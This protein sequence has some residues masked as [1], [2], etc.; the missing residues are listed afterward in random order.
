MKKSL[1]ILAITALIVGGCGQAAKEQKLAIEM[2]TEFFT[3]SV[4]EMSKEEPDMQV[5]DSIIEQYVAAEEQLRSTIIYKMHRI[6]MET[7]TITPDDRRKDA[8]QV[9]WRSYNDKECRTF[10]LV[11][12]KKGK[13][14]IN[15]W[16]GYELYEDWY[17]DD[18]QDGY[19]PENHVKLDAALL[20]LTKRQGMSAQ[21]DSLRHA[22]AFASEIMDLNMSLLTL[23]YELGEDFYSIDANLA[24]YVQWG[25]GM[26]PF[27]W[28]LDYAHRN[29]SS[30]MAG[31]AKLI[32]RYGTLIKLLVPYEKYTDNGWDWIVVQ[33][34][35]AY[36][37][38]SVSADNFGKVYEIM[39]D[40]DYHSTE[41]LAPF[42]RDKQ[43]TVFTDQ[44][45]TGY[46]SR[47][48]WAYSFWGRRYN[49]NSDNIPHLV[50]AL[51]T[52]REHYVPNAEPLETD[53]NLPPI[54]PYLT[55]DLR[56]NEPLYPWKLYTDRV[57][58]V[59][60]DDGHDY[61]SML[62]EKDGK[63]HWLID[64][65][66]GEIIL[67]QGDVINLTWSME[68]M[69]YYDIEGEEAKFRMSAHSIKLIEATATTQFK[70]KYGSIPE[71]HWGD[72]AVIDEETE[73]KLLDKLL[74][75]LLESDNK[76]I[77]KVSELLRSPQK[78]NLSIIIYD[79]EENKIKPQGTLYG[80]PVTIKL[81][82]KT[83]E[84][85]ITI[86]YFV[87]N[88][89]TDVLHIDVDMELGKN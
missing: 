23:G 30:D 10:L 52:I 24:K 12:N 81:D 58:V 63:Q 50:A 45:D 64:N 16:D 37:D 70:K 49:E 89:D 19:L 32:R 85:D 1:I 83:D 74:I 54:E 66:D 27:R 41:E 26:E 60:Y 62:V 56:P 25:T 73:K 76:K 15:D 11:K 71:V 35:T 61:Y 78:E 57:Q 36:E 67:S 42:I 8:Y 82:T 48:V 34:L 75:S 43:L 46:D 77:M 9:C 68:I 47:V 80:Y 5:M 86:L 2:L 14:L 59:K 53:R 79:C 17:D 87:Y 55:S 69:G 7:L 20:A 39:S 29:R 38:L 44:A 21:Y 88:P 22:I 84:P 40:G 51:K 33:L 13:Y 65:S 4:A 18:D 31:L 3:L 72:I 6:D 28:L